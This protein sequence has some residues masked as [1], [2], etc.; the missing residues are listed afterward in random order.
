MDPAL[1]RAIWQQ[2]KL[3]QLSMLTTPPQS[4]SIKAPGELSPRLASFLHRR[5]F[6]H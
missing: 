1:N 4:V 6:T 2:S 3:V 5:A